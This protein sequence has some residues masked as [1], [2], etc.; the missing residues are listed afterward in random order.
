LLDDD[1]AILAIGHQDYV[2]YAYDRKDAL[3][4][5]LQEAFAC[6]EEVKKLFRLVVAAEWPET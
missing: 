2:F 4:G 3:H 5:Q 1:V 6:P